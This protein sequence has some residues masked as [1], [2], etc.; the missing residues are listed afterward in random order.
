MINIATP[1]AIQLP[2]LKTTHI[3]I[4]TEETT[5]DYQYYTVCHWKHPSVLTRSLHPHFRATIFSSLSAFLNHCSFVENAAS[6]NS[7]NLSL[8]FTYCR[9]PHRVFC[10]WLGTSSASAIT[11]L[12]TCSC[13]NRQKR[14]L[15][16]SVFSFSC[17][18]VRI[19]AGF[20]ILVL[21]TALQLSPHRKHQACVRKVENR[22]WKLGREHP[23]TKLDGARSLLHLASTTERFPGLAHT[24]T[25]RL[26][27]III[28]RSQRK[29]QRVLRS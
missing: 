16:C 29:L 25:Q 26:V 4:L 9:P 1:Y 19:V 23:S 5:N 3:H 2:S 8:F 24:S 7:F 15:P 11:A 22:Y 10:I 18:R 14:V 21:L 6:F 20:P 12:S 13:S 17:F 27:F 28:S